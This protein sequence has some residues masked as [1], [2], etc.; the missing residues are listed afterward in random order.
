MLNYGAVY[1]A[2]WGLGFYR[3]TTF[4]T[5]VGVD[6]GPAGNVIRNE[7]KISPNPIHDY[8]TIGFHLNQ[9]TSCGIYVY[10]LNG[11]LVMGGNLGNKPAGDNTARIDFSSLS[12]GMYI[13]RVNN[14]YGKAVKQ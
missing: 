11:N 7:L 12:T 13:I 6:P 3:D 4:L 8:A 10:D 2:T 1:A 5:P 9:A 14:S